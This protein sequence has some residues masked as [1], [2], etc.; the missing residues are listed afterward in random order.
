VAEQKVIS[1]LQNP[2][3]L[4]ALAFVLAVSLY[5]FMILQ[6]TLVNQVIRLGS[7]SNVRTITPIAVSPD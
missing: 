5:L 3:K 2:S 6:K 1:T 7:A 4:L